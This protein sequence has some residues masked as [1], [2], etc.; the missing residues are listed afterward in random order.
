MYRKMSSRRN[1]FNDRKN[2]PIV[3]SNL[4]QEISIRIVIFILVYLSFYFFMHLHIDSYIPV[5]YFIFKT[6][7]PVI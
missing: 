3:R 7:L 2:I 6:P 4:N 5:I 1:K